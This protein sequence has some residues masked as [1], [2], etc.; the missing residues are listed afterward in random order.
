M[1]CFDLLEKI[2]QFSGMSQNS[3]A[4]SHVAVSEV[5]ALEAGY[6][7][8]GSCYLEYRFLFY[9]FFLSRSLWSLGLFGFNVL[10]GEMRY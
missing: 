3:P 5:R 6:P 2:I 10:I 1:C 4:C 8:E 7:S 9:L